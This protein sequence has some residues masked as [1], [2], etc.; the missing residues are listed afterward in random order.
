[1]EN[2]KQIE[3]FPNYEVSDL[4]NI[5]RGKRNIFG[6]VCKIQSITN[7]IKGVN[8]TCKNFIWKYK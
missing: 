3:E 5:R 6:G 2:Y 4:G 8:K 1:M 7:A